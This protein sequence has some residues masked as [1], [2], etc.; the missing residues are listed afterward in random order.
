MSRT[1]RRSRRRCRSRATRAGSRSCRCSSRGTRTTP[2]PTR[3]CACSATS[4]GSRRSGRT[5]TARSCARPSSASSA[6]P[7]S[8]ASAG[9]NQT[10]WTLEQEYLY[11]LLIHQLNTGNMTPRRDRLGVLAA[12]RV[13]PAPR[14]RRGAALAGRLLRRH[15]GPH[16]AA[17][18]HRQRLGLDAALPRHVA[19]RRP[20]RARD[21]RAAPGRG[22]RPGPAAPINQQRIAIL[23]K[24]RPS[25]APNVHHRP[26]ARSAHRVQG[27]GASVRI[28]LARICREFGAKDVGDAA[29]DGGGAE[30]IE[31]YAVA[32]APRAKRP[33]PDEHDSLVASLSSFSDPMWQVKDRSVAGLRIAASGGIGQSLALGA[34]VA[35]R[36]SDVVRLGARRRAAPE[37]GERPR[38]SRRACR[39]SPSASCRSRCSRAAS[40][41]TTWASSSTAST[42]RRWARASTRSTCRRRRGPTSR[43]R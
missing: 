15:R 35:V 14:A 33:T 2:A 23:E 20:D 11:V 37:Q 21:P 17:A 22:H 30:Q 18:P 4:A 34:L 10:Q 1:R 16:G 12:A 36:Q 40:R 13:E 6:S 3:S 5:C 41:A 39:S 28:G 9:P 38:R 29:A 7:T 32:D 42:S 19:A 43:S 8:L 26:A 24:V 25:V 31:V 27:V